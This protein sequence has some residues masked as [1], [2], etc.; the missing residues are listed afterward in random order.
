MTSRK[1]SSGEDPVDDGAPTR[2]KKTKV[3]SSTPGKGSSGTI[4]S[5]GDRYWEISK[6]RR[7]TVNSFR[8]KMMVAVRE[9]YEKDGQDLPGKKVSRSSVACEALT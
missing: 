1:R 5:N 3:T 4:D 9:Y 8:G 6:N 7:V 2:S